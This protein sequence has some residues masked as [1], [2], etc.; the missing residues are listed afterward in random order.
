VTIPSG[1]TSATFTISTT[2]AKAN[3]S[4]TIGAAFGTASQTAILTIS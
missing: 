3:T 1:K 2:K 4:A